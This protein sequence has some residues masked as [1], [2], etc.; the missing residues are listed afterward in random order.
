MNIIPQEGKNGADGDSDSPELHSQSEGFKS[1]STSPS[2][3][4]LRGE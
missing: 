4:N 3:R 2:K 1:L